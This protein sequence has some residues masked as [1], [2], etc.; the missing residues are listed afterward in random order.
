[1]NLIQP[2]FQVIVN[3]RY[4]L[5]FNTLEIE[6]SNKATVVCD[7]ITFAFFDDEK[8]TAMIHDTPTTIPPK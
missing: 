5:A 7:T 4:M 1:M 3:N 8:E 2:G 6:K